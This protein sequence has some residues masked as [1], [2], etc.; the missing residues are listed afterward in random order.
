MP[1]NT[2][3]VGPAL[4][5]ASCV[6]NPLRV[7][8]GP[9]TG[10]SFAMQRRVARLLEADGVD[11]RRILAV[12]FTR[13]AAGNLV[14]DLN[15]LGVAGCQDIRSGTLHAFCFS[16]LSRQNVLDY[17]GRTARSLITFNKAGVAQFEYQ[18][19]LQD[20]GLLGAF[21]NKRDRTKRIRAFEA[22][23]ARLQHE[24][25][26]WALAA[27]D[28]Q[29]QQA[30]LDWL[31]FH[32]AMLIGELV[33]ESLRFLRNNPATP[34]LHAFDHV[35]VDEYQDLNKAEQV[36]LDLLS[37]DA[38]LSIVGDIDQS[39][40]SFR[41]ANPQGIAA[42]S[43]RHPTTHDE[44]LQECRR[45]PRRVVE[46]A[47]YFIRHNH[48]SGAGIRLTPMPGNPDGEVHI[49][50]WTTMELEAEG[51]ARFVQHLINSRGYAPGEILILSS[52]RLLGYGIRDTLQVL[53]IPTHSFYH[54]EA[55]E[56]PEAREAFTLMT[57]L[58]QPDD[59]VALR[60]WL[61]L[62]SPSWRAGAYSTLREHCEGS[63]QSAREALND[64]MVGRLS[65]PRTAGLLS[66][67]RDLTMRLAALAGLECTDITNSLFPDGVEWARVLRETAL[68]VLDVVETPADLFEELRIQI[69][70][71]EMPSE[72][73][74]VRVMSLHKSKGLTT[75]VAV[76]AGCIEGLIP[77][78]DSADTAAEAQANLEEQ[79]RLFYVA[80]TRCREVLALS[81][82][83]RLPV[84]TAYR[85]GAEVRGRRGVCRTIASR[86]LDELGPNSPAAVAGQDWAVGG[87][88]EA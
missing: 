74:F 36:L 44:P 23:W 64:M 70:Q 56:T 84:Q 65:L 82:V 66:R 53:G 11:P 69:T 50:Q 71:P 83:L 21:G 32:H 9:G 60:F 48:P 62:A 63:G 54:E 15:N 29:F 88:A 22:A 57:L 41:F 19:M 85:L 2:G 3:L 7:M 12:T 34:E 30:L 35:V 31:R 4:N 61:G 37:H 78:V 59:R 6:A 40:Y 27:A 33:P 72:G 68:S 49:V 51:L 5:I 77:T 80:I 67:Y 10:K 73:D 13:N 14:Q 81:S 39:I 86:F 24:E 79:R 52:R 16:L 45:C 76:V 75:R 38:Q 55:L 47:D 43:N 8:A 18:P 1:W 17:L 28:G 20:I 42:F 58:A 87:Y 26:G 46:L 25:P